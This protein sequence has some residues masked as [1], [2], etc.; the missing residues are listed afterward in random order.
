MDDLT[1]KIEHILGSEEGQAQLKELAAMF[2]GENGEMPDLSAIGDMFGSAQ[3]GESNSG[4]SADN[5][6]ILGDIDIGML[7][8]MKDMFSSTKASDKNSQLLLALRPHLKDKN[9]EKVDGAIKIMKLIS[10][11][12]LIK[13]SGLFGGEFF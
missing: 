2:G 11:L 4:Q 5:D 3:D 13:D 12:P 7:L 10:L 1:S 9:K 6:S 8:K